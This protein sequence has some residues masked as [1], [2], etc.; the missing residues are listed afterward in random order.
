MNLRFMI[1][2][3]RLALADERRPWIFRN[4]QIASRNRFTCRSR[5]EQP[6]AQFNSAERTAVT[7]AAWM[8][9]PTR[10]S[11]RTGCT[12]SFRRGR[13]NSRTASPAGTSSKSCPH[14]S[15]WRAWASWARAAAGR[16]KNWSR[17]ASSRKIT[18][19][20]NRNITQR[21]CPRA[22]G[23]SRSSSNPTKAAR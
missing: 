5:N 1:Y 11:S 4:R 17:S 10:R 22:R 12:A 7:G 21:P 13:A 20:V 3:L 8:N 16:R 6:F 19:S 2:D 18:R 9:W 15:R 14:L 23:R